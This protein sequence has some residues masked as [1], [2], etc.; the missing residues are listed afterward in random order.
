M[1][2][3]FNHPFV[4][5]VIASLVAAVIFALFLPLLKKLAKYGLGLLDF[6]R[7]GVKEKT[8]LDTYRK[9]LEEKTPRIS[10]PWMKEDQFLTDILVPIYTIP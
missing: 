7:R 3:D 5:G 6:F 4:Q 8:G 2:I 9:T 1:N 10:H